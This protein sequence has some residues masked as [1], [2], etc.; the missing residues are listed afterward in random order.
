MSL[1]LAQSKLRKGIQQLRREMREKGAA[2]ARTVLAPLSNFAGTGI[3]DTAITSV[4]ESA[5]PAAIARDTEVTTAVSNHAGAADPHTG[6]VLE[7][8]LDAKGDLFAASAADTPVRLAVG[9]NGHPL[10]ADS[11]QSTGLRYAQLTHEN[12]VPGSPLEGD[13]ILMENPPVLLRRGSAAYT[14]WGPIQKLYLPPTSGWSWQNQGAA[15]LTDYTYALHLSHPAGS[16]S[17]SLHS[18]KRTFA[19]PG[20]YNGVQA[21]LLPHITDTAGSAYLGMRESATNK[22]LLFHFEPDGRFSIKRWTSDTV[23]ASTPL[24]STPLGA[25]RTP[26]IYMEADLPGNLSFWLSFD[27]GF[28]PL[29]LYSEADT[30]HFTTGP[31]EW[32]WGINIVTS[33]SPN[34]GLAMLLSWYDQ[35]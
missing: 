20:T 7:S 35:S 26:N 23:V 22:L 15:S 29:Q 28:A 18:R 31:D 2:E 33:G 6:Y 5:I 3:R 19:A 34:G 25:W 21:L 27:T 13:L 30:A 12:A 1:R 32:V 24:A 8:L 16:G 17:A 9:T 10:R 11:A 4:P 14:S